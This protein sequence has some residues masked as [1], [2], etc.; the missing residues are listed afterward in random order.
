MKLEEKKQTI[1]HHLQSYFDE[2]NSF[3]K[4]SNFVKSD[5][6]TVHQQKINEVIH[7]L[8]WDNSILEDH[9]SKETLRIVSWNIER[10]KAF[11]DLVQFFKEDAELSKADVI[12]AIECDS[13]MGRTANRNVAKELAEAL[14]MNYCFA[15]SYLV[16]GKGAVGE[17]DH[18]HK[19]TTALHGTSI[20][21]KYKITAAK[22]VEVPPVK[23]VF[24]SSEKRLG[25]K[26]GLII[27]I[28][29]GTKTLSFG[30]IHIDL[31]STAKDR[32]NQLEAIVKNMPPTA[33]Q[34]V[35]GDWNCGTFNLRRKWE[36]I[37]Q[38]MSKLMTIG[39]TKAIEHYMT[40]EL[41]FE[42]P[43]FTMLST[44][45]FDFNTYNDRL[46]GTLYFDVNQVLT[47]DKIKQF[48]PAFFTKELHRRLQPWK[49]CVPLKID[50]LAGKG[51]TVLNAQTIEKPQVKGRFLSDHNPI[52]IDLKLA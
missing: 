2:I 18:H 39:F 50:W 16:L 6:Y 35:G 42:Q 34:I 49:G 8:E 4:K 12:L 52:Y 28:E 32:A 30:A 7:G 47:N 23:E 33:I 5:F 37:T 31:S 20:L 19:N 27:E 10:G 48:V 1:T 22:S 36:I 46:K 29:V 40:P 3:S 24:H 17:T 21:S 45:G 44:N 43:L 38:S 9:P 25:T 15:P 11:V 14:K 41:K 26:K 51:G 13:G